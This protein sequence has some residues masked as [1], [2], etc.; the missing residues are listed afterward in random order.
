[1]IKRCF[2][3]PLVSGGPQGLAVVPECEM[4]MSHR[5][6]GCCTTLCR[7]GLATVLGTDWQ[8]CEGL[9]DHSAMGWLNLTTMCGVG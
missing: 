4:L 7:A 6:K 2:L 1:M 9:V 3:H 8:Q 5:V